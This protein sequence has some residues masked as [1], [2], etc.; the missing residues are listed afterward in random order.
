MS[1]THTDAAES[2]EAT[3]KGKAYVIVGF[4]RDGRLKPSVGVLIVPKA[5]ETEMPKAP[6]RRMLDKMG[7]EKIE[8]VEAVELV[9]IPS[10]QPTLYFFE[11]M[12]QPK[13]FSMAHVHNDG[14]LSGVTQVEGH[15][16]P[17]V[18]QLRGNAVDRVI[19][20]CGVP[21]VTDIQRKPHVRPENHMRKRRAFSG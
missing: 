12:P 14:S 5:L 6:D 18:P 19:P 16:Q 11:R 8:S 21:S 20:Q 2:A 17:Y 15:L 4:R 9:G 10:A 7:F 3:P 13:H 1:D